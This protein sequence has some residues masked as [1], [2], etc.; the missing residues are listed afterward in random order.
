MIEALAAFA[1]ICAVAV[2]LVWREDHRAKKA[3]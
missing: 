3:H 1:L 2:W